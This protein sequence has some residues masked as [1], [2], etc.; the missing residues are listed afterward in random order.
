[1][2][3]TE[4]FICPATNQPCEYY[5]LCAGMKEEVDE[6]GVHPESVLAHDYQVLDIPQD[7]QEAMWS[8]FCSNER[9]SAVG[10][11]AT[12]NSPSARAAIA[13]MVGMQRGRE[14]AVSNPDN[15]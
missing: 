7:V 15:L 5:H 14:I 9:L 12:S 8:S 10:R 4:E 13:V 3:F 11:I 1:M 2:A 6:G